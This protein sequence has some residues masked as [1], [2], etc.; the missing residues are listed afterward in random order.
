MRFFIFIITIALAFNPIIGN[1][2]ELTPEK[3]AAIKEL[4]EISG[5]MQVGELFGNAFAQQMTQV[6]QSSHP[7]IDPR[8][9]DIV[10]EEAQ[11][12]IHEELVVKESYY[13]YIYPIYNKYL[14][15]E[16]TRGLIDFY[17]TPIGRK[18]IAVMPKMVQEGMVAGQ[19]WGQSIAPQFERR[20]LERLKKEGI[21]IEK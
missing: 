18:A 15:L 5:A 6:L 13:P 14:T 17:K 16:E 12:L 20:V 9:F 19:L 11:A 8:A 2:E 3:K 1:C 21:K 4:L 10:K 7:D